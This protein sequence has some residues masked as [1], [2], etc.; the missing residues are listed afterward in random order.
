MIRTSWLLRWTL[1]IT[2]SLW[3]TMSSGEIRISRLCTRCLIGTWSLIGTRCLIEISVETRS[4]VKEDSGVSC[5]LSVFRYPTIYFAPVGKKGEPIRYEVTQQLFHS[6]DNKYTVTS[7]HVT[8][9]GHVTS[10]LCVF[11]GVG[12]S[13]TSWSFWNVRRVT[14]CCSAGRR[15]NS[16]TFSSTS[17]VWLQGQPTRLRDN[18]HVAREEGTESWSC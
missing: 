9:G 8:A 10:L 13:K 4:R 7:R 17:Q 11:R 14:V 16:D 6:T 15:T 1:L 18:R 3:D 2:T 5:L 12:S